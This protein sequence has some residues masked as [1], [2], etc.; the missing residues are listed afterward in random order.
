MFESFIDS[1]DVGVF[2]LDCC[3][4]VNRVNRRLLEHYRWNKEELVGQNLFAL[5]PDLTALGVEERFHQI[6]AQRRSMELTNIQRKDRFGREAV[7]NLTGMP[8]LENGDIIGVL[9]VMND[10]TEKRALESQVAETEEYLK[11][12]I[13]NA[14]DVIYTLDRDGYI[15]FL[16]KMG[17]QVTGYQ[18]NPNEK[19]HYSLYVP[20]RTLAKHDKYFREAING[21]PQRYES[22]IVSFDSR[23]VNVLINTTPIRRGDKVVGILGIARDI[24]ER[25][26]MEAQLLQAGKMAAIGELAS[27]VAHEINNPVGIISGAAEQLLFLMEHYREHP[28]EMLEKL[29]KHAAT[30]REQAAR[31]KRIT[32]GL[33]NFARKTEVKKSMVSLPKVLEETIAL[34][35][36]R[37]LSEKKSITLDVAHDIPILDADSNQLEQVFLNLINNALDA[38]DKDGL[39]VVRAAKEDDSVVVDV[40]DNGLGISEENLKKIFNPFFT[41]KAPGKGTGLGLSICFGIIQNMNG[42]ITA[43]SKPGTGTTFSIHLPL[44]R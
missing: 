24:T 17:Q 34:V 27:G 19:G 22:A 3:G 33:L 32:Q 36:N 10:I 21:K 15:T 30:I 14:N 40:I 4:T 7:F 41:T 42:T 5:V 39:V 16:N 37:A 43:S 29:A 31:C 11:S 20:R 25:K 28:E 38:I 6:V 26:Q 44:G 12:L 8:I 35:G 1:I 9:A 18:F 2:V 23:I 13:D